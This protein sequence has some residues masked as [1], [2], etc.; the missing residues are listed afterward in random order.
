VRALCTT[1]E[2]LEACCSKVQPVERNHGLLIAYDALS[3]QLDRCIRRG[4]EPCL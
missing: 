2:H 3:D 1:S 4:E